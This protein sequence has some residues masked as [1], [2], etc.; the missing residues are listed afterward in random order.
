MT[1]EDI[2]PSTDPGD[3]KARLGVAAGLLVAYAAMWF[4]IRGAPDVPAASS[5]NAPAF[6][7]AELAA[8]PASGQSSQPAIAVGEA[9]PAAMPAA[10]PGATGKPLAIVVAH[11]KAARI[12]AHGALHYDFVLPATDQRCRLAGQLHGNG[13]YNRDLETFLL[14]DDDY[15]FWQANP[16]AIPHSSWETF[17]GSETTFSYD[18]AAA[19]TYHLVVSNGMSPTNTGVQVKA[20]VT[21]SGQSP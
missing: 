4:L 10:A 9:P 5:E 17:R 6:P 2:P 19:G 7:A 20:Q 13:G 16:A 21:C 11:D 1:P 8:E 15:V 12:Q 18:L 14:T 3:R